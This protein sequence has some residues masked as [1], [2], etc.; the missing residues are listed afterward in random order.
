MGP[1]LLSHFLNCYVPVLHNLM[2]AG[3][4]SAFRLMARAQY[5]NQLLSRASWHNNSS[6]LQAAKP[7][8]GS[9]SPV[10]SLADLERGKQRA[11]LHH[12]IIA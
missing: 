1:K 10:Y 6:R 4:S 5:R 3:M 12:L 11:C 9:G 2:P 8:G 7:H